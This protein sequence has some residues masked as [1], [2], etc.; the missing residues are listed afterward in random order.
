MYGH[1]LQALPVSLCNRSLDHSVPPLPHIERL[2]TQEGQQ[3]PQVLHAVLD[4]GPWM[5]GRQT[6]HAYE[7]WMRQN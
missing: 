3:H 2:Q 4:R 6:H 1:S 7:H 5:G